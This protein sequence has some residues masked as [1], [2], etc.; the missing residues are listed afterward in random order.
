MACK[1]GVLTANGVTVLPHIGSISGRVAGGTYTPGTVPE[2]GGD[3]VAVPFWI[4]CND[5]S[6]A[7]L[8]ITAFAA[9]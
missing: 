7:R 9:D 5:P 2:P 1:A 8:A 6:L 3:W 4:A